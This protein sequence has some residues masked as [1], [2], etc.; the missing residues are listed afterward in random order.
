M[1]YHTFKIQCFTSWSQ[2]SFKKI[3]DVFSKEGPIGF[4]PCR[5]M[6]HKI[7]LVLGASLPNRP[8]Y[9]TNSKEIK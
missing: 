5:G 1:H 6:E 9:K 8:T 7:D 4:P 3:G 2:N